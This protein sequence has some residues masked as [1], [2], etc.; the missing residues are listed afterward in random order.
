[1]NLLSFMSFLILGITILTM[2]F[3]VLAYFLYKTR[4]R[5]QHK[6]LESYEQVLAKSEDDYLFFTKED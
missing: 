4:E 2:V 1:M 6:A 3:G 5:K